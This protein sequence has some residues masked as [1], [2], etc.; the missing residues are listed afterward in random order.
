MQ[1]EEIMSRDVVT[2]PIEATVQ[3]AAEIMVAEEVGSVIVLRGGDPFGIVTDSDVVRA[4]AE[5]AG[6]F[7]DIPLEDVVNHPLVTVEPDATVRTAVERMRTEGIKR[8]PVV[9]GIDLVGIIT[10]TD[11]VASYQT[12][13]HEAYEIRRQREQWE[14]KD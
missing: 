13:V 7:N 2:C 10:R 6:S 5:T 3:R 12:L 4:G 14:T 9:S 1:V 11:I 8:L